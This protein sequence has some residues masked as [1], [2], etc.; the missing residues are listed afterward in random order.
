[1]RLINSITLQL[2]EFVTDRIP[3]YVIL[4]HTWGEEEV[5]FRDIQ[6][7]NA[8]EMKGFVKLQNCCAQ[9]V[10][11]G[12]DYAWID[13]C[14]IDKSSSAELSEAINSMYKWYKNAR[15]CYAYLED[16]AIPYSI[17]DSQFL[18]VL[19]PSRWFTRGWTLQEL[20]APPIVEF[21][22]RDWN[23]FGSKNSRQ[24]V[25]SN[26]TGIEI[27]VLRGDDPWACNVA[28]RMSWASKRTTTRAEDI[29]YCLMGLFNVNM[30]LLYGEGGSKA[31]NRLQEEIIKGTE[32]HSLFAWLAHDVQP[33]WTCRGL[34]ASSPQEFGDPKSGLLRMWQYSDLLVGSSVNFGTA[35]DLWD[36]PHSLTSRGLRISLPLRRKGGEYPQGM[37]Y[38]ACINCRIAENHKL[39]CVYLQRLP[40]Q[41]K[42]YGR[43]RAHEVALLPLEEVNTFEYSTIYVVQTTPNENQLYKLKNSIKMVPTNWNTMV[44]RV[45]LPNSLYA[46]S[47]QDSRPWNEAQ[48]KTSGNLTVYDESS[49]IPGLNEF[50]ISNTH[51]IRVKAYV[52]PKIDYN[53]RVHIDTWGDSILNRL[54]NFLYTWMAVLA[55]I[56]LL[57]PRHMLTSDV[58]LASHCF[59][60]ANWIAI[61][62]LALGQPLPSPI[63]SLIKHF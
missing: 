19:R 41:D 22:D 25:L 26:I 57:H 51:N 48:H 5:S 56:E 17:P 1:M 6:G 24:E 54:V 34:L 4:S 32:D 55:Y 28:Q 52:D 9:A 20:I 46:N 10:R 11:D 50:D 13:T 44:I 45:L 8:K 15:I 63:L 33:L 18:E 47:K 31:F 29:A 39:L 35:R 21:Y 23:N 42:L 59:T 36:D 27:H 61:S 7:P 30:P 58:V 37:E 16:I 40:N 49:L 38:L 60:S 12:F 14:C 62:K 2:E 3:E 43:V 53:F